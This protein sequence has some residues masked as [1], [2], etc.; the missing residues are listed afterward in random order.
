M[1]TL[2]KNWTLLRLTHLVVSL[3][4]LGCAFYFHHNIYLYILGGG[5]LAQAL[6][7]SGCSNNSC[8]VPS[9][10]YRNTRYRRRH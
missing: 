1:N 3:V 8:D 6:L 7:H 5:F 4:L 10:K 9:G 2:L